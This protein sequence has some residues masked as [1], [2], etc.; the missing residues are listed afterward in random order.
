MS[1]GFGRGGRWGGKGGKRL[2][3][4]AVPKRNRGPLGRGY[5]GGRWAGGGKEK[6]DGVAVYVEMG[7]G[8]GGHR[9]QGAAQQALG[10]NRPRSTL[11]VRKSRTD[12]DSLWALGKRH[13]QVAHPKNDPHKRDAGG[14]PQALPPPRPCHCA[15]IPSHLYVSGPASV[16]SR[17][18]AGACPAQ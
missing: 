8:S 2:G 3:V 11:Q 4:E 16:S 10:A 13:N 17:D 1:D 7:T 6:A 5:C 9:S 18:A 12:G 14:R 15:A